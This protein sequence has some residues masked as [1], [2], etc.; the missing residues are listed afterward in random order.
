MTSH[1]ALLS[2]EDIYDGHGLKKE[3][4]DWLTNMVGKR[5]TDM[6]ELQWTSK[7]W[8]MER[9]RS[10]HNP[11]YFTISARSNIEAQSLNLPLYLHFQFYNPD[12]A[13]MFKL[14]WGGK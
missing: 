6:T 7:M 14:A 12:H 10:Y 11:K 5:A 3:I 9:T 13:M 4:H 1:V 8:Y 2:T